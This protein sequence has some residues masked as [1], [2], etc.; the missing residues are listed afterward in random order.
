MVSA[1]TALLLGA[2]G[3][4]GVGALYLYNELKNKEA[5]PIQEA[6]AIGQGCMV[7]DHVN[8]F[9]SEVKKIEKTYT[10]FRIH[11]LNGNSIPYK[12]ELFHLLNPHQVMIGQPAHFLY[13]VGK[14]LVNSPKV[15]VEMERLNEQYNLEKARASENHIR[16]MRDVKEIMGKMSDRSN[17]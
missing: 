1:S 9:Q 12:A 14:E 11:F 6:S 17:E 7:T 4:I 10:G 2:L 3:L 15:V 13:G 8:G 5:D 16:G